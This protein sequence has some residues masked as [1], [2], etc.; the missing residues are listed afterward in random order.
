MWLRSCRQCSYSHFSLRVVLRS[1]EAQLEGWKTIG[2]NIEP[3]LNF[4]PFMR[5]P[6]DWI[7]GK[8]NASLV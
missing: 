7:V 6:V 5:R 2:T 8:F 4:V 3:L 1:R